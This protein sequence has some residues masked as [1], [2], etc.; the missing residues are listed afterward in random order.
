MPHHEQMISGK[1]THPL[2]IYIMVSAMASN[3]CSGWFI[4]YKP[5]IDYIRSHV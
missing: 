2:I 1:K 5:S 4:I 3:I